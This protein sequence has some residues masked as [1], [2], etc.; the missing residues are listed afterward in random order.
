M[1]QVEVIVL[2]CLC[3]IGVFLAGVSVSAAKTKTITISAAGDCTFSSDIKQPSSVN[4][5][6]VYKKKGPKYFF[7][8]VASVFKKDNLSLV[9]FEGTL[10]NRGSRVDKK[11]AFRG[12]PKYAKILKFG[13]IEA[14]GFANNH[15]KDYGDVSYQDTKKALEKQKILYSSSDNICVTKVKG[16]KVG[17]ISVSSIDAT[18]SPIG[19]LRSLLKKMK[20]KKPG[21]LIISIHSGT[22]Y[23]SQATQMQEQLAHIAVDEGGANLVIGHH[24]HVIQGIEKRK[25]SLIVYSLG[26]FV[27]GGNTNPK[28]KDTMIF[29]Q[30]FV[31]KDGKVQKKKSKAKIIPCS[32]SSISTI[33]NYQPMVVK[34][35]T[36]QRII[37][38]LNGMSQKYGIKI[39]KSGAIG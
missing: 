9:N 7:K 24:P 17:M 39:Q 5:F 12:K 34:G 31:V 15:V 18:Y 26:N 35:K 16:V 27:F 4:F 36:K 3:M 22:E 6:S 33:N 30:T 38:R 29:Q 13:S 11:W 2:L 20:K 37:T 8:K 32:L 28:D 14:V 10:S 25:G 19:K 21:I 23:A 1:R